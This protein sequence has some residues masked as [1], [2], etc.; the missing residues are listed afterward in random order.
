ME[1]VFK[2]TAG[3]KDPAESGRLG[4]WFFIASEI[5]LFG[6][7]LAGYVMIRW[8]SSVCALGTPA[9]PEAG[10]TGG[11]AL[12]TLNTVILL[13]S[14]LTMVRATLFARD[15]NAAGVRKNLGSTLCLGVLFL[16][17]KSCE[18]AL[19]IH[20]GYYPKSEFMQANPGLTI[21]I[22]FYYALTILHALHVIVGL[23]WNGALY[24]SMSR[25]WRPDL[26]GKMEYAGLY[27]HFV[28]VL[29]LFLFPLF[30]LI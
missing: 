3:A 10:Y 2:G 9:W 15:G 29:W 19:K 4:L 21:F 12:A 27:W 5:L 7:F 22:S 1:T 25:G 30:Y 6:G 13:T 24:R 18:Y 8:G 26:S 20:H 17:V 16:A 14:S 28:D 11:L 23:I